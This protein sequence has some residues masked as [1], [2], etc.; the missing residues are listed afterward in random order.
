VGLAVETRN[1]E[2][3]AFRAQKRAVGAGLCSGIADGTSLL[4]ARNFPAVTAPLGRNSSTA[5]DGRVCTPC[6]PRTSQPEL[7]LPY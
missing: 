2:P 5:E 6:F 1:N 4:P 7:Q 3:G